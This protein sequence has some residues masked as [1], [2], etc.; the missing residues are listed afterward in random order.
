M[1]QTNKQ[2]FK[3]TY[4]ETKKQTNK[5]T[6]IEKKHAYIQIHTYIHKQILSVYAN[7]MCFSKGE[8]PIQRVDLKTGKI[9]ITKLEG[10]KINYKFVDFS[11]SD[12]KSTISW[13]YINKDADDAWTQAFQNVGVQISYEEVMH[14][15]SK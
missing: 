9:V 12:L 13:E 15:P 8:K 6:N 3:Q 10:G 7:G 1:K 14:R 4:T 11:E 5:Q 2:T